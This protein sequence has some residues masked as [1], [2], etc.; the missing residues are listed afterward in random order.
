MVAGVHALVASSV[1]FLDEGLDG[2]ARSPLGLAPRRVVCVGR[3]QGVTLLLVGKDVQ[4]VTCITSSARSTYARS[5][6]S[7]GFT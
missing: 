1:Q 5:C 3:H 4:R 2:D 6:L 7:T